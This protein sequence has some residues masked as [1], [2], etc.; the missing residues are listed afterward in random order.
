[1]SEHEHEAKKASIVVFS[2]DMDKVMAAF[3]IA[4]T[5]AASGI[6]TTMFFTFWALQALKKKVPTGRTLF[7]RML[8]MFLRD[9]DGI[10][11]SKLNMGGMGRW[12]FKKMMKQHQVATLP[13]LRQMAVDL[14]VKLLACQMSMEVMGIRREDLIDE[15]TDVVGAATYVAEANQSHITLFI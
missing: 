12:M 7:E 13:E 6:E 8:S 11:P 15:V 5:A 4:T 1:M 9:I 2:G 10:G 14:G 3:I